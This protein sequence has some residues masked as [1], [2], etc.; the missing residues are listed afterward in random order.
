MA[1]EVLRERLVRVAREEPEHLIFF[2][3]NDT[4]LTTA[5]VRRRLRNILAEAGITGVTYWWYLA[6]ID[7]TDRIAGRQVGTP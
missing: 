7:L 6:T 5:N 2:N 3:R 4:P 1:A